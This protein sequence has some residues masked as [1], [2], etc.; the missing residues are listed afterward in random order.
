MVAYAVGLAMIA[1]LYVSLVHFGSGVALV[2]GVA[3]FAAMAVAL[4][5]MILR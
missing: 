5:L 4:A 1:G 2:F 3:S